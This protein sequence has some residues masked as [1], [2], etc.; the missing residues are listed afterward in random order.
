M[1]V[2]GASTCVSPKT[3]LQD[4]AVQGGSLYTQNEVSS[5]V[6]DE[7]GYETFASLGEGSAI[8]PGLSQGF[9]P[10]GLAY[11]RDT[12]W[13][14]V[15]GYSDDGASRLIVIDRQ[16]G[17]LLKVLTL[18]NDDGSLFNGHSGGVA[19]DMHSVYI[20]SDGFVYTASLESI[21]QAGSVDTLRFLS[22]FK[23]PTNASFCTWFNGILWVG[24]FYYGK[25]YP[26]APYKHRVNRDGEPTRAW[27]AG[28]DS[29]PVAGSGVPDYILSVGDRI[30]GMSVDDASHIVLSQSY[31]RRNDSALLFF[32][33][34]LGTEPDEHVELYGSRV[35]LWHLDGYNAV[36]TLC[37]PPMSEGIAWT[38]SGIFVLFESAAKKYMH[39]SPKSRN[40]LDR[41]WRLKPELLASWLAS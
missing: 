15:S 5:S 6:L 14:L 35:P 3:S 21:R 29:E 2:L 33:T 40:P 1:L 7:Q 38:S 27:I 8:I 32:N 30:Q 11:W 18:E 22:S 20:A 26:S 24:D 36:K 12:D 41:I 34:P 31:G 19:L 17:D 25:G 28:Y 9:V 10:Q 23:T 13:L 37:A 4:S 16:H 39:G